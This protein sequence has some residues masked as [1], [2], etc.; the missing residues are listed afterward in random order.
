[1]TL[2]LLLALAGAPAM[3]AEE[4]EAPSAELLE[5][6]GSFETVDG[7]WLDPSDFAI[8]LLGVRLADNGEKSDE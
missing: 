4:T 5:F 2:S 1:M 3:A 8:P 7:A 6:L